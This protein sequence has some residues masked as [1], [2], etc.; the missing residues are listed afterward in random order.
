MKSF[1][2]WLNIKESNQ[3][4]QEAKAKRTA[5]KN[6]SSAVMNAGGLQMADMNIRLAGLAGADKLS[7]FHDFLSRKIHET[8]EGKMRIFDFL[9]NLTDPSNFAWTLKSE[10]FVKALQFAYAAIVKYKEV[11]DAITD[12]KIKQQANRNLEPMIAAY[13]ELLALNKTQ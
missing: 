3:F 8:P 2:E 5:L 4:S 9:N 10:N 13:T 1:N 7:Q 6:L 11:L 12:P